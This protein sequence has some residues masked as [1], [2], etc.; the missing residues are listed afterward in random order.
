MRRVIRD[1]A[2]A[3]RLGNTGQKRIREL[4]DPAT[5]GRRYE[6]RLRAIKKIG[7]NA[8]FRKLSPQKPS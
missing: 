8:V 7:K 6:D 1:P 4:Y 3:K 5:I 2:F